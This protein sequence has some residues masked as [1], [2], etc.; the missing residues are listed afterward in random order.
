MSSISKKTK[1]QI[2]K[3]EAM[4]VAKRPIF[5]KN[6]RPIMT[7]RDL[8]SRGFV[9]FTSSV[10]VPGV[11]A[12]LSQRA[13]GIECV[14]KKDG[15]TPIPFMVMDLGGGANFAMGNVIAGKKGGQK[16]FLDDA[17]AA[18]LGC[19][20]DQNPKNN[21]AMAVPINDNADGNGLLFHANSGFLAG[22]RA[23]TSQTTRANVDGMLFCG[24]SGDDTRNNPLNPVYWIQSAGATGQLVDVVGAGDG[25]ARGRSQAPADSITAASSARV[26]N[27]VDAVSLI[28]TGLI[29]QILPNQADKIMKAA[30]NL[31]A[32]Q[33][34]AFNKKS[35]SEQ[36][37][38]LVQCGYIKATENLTKFTPNAVRPDNDPM[39]AQALAINNINANPNINNAFTLPNNNNEQDQVTTLAKLVIDGYAGSATMT[40]GG[41]DYHGQGRRTQTIK[42]FNA[43]VHAGRAFELAALKG[44]P[45]MMAFITDGGVSARTDVDN[46]PEAAGRFSFRS[47]SGTRS[48]AF[49][50]CFNPEG[51]ISTG[52]RQVGAFLDGSGAVD[53]EAS[54][55]GDSPINLTK[56]IA[57]NYMALSGT[58][59]DFAKVVQTNPFSDVAK[60][61]GFKS[62]K[63]QG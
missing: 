26:T 42:D 41:Y 15:G 49:M 24:R 28:D 4:P 51:L 46:S 8:I 2:E 19:P 14:S 60:V 53:L 52:V 33:L 29:G 30:Q 34:M 21:P 50:L 38:T 43:G 5:H 62:I 9:S 6:H 11:L 23:V 55:V 17:A 58:E 16:D 20:S 35:V 36:V 47:D 32:S 61:I 59:A 3:I 18:M 57:L 12:S 22:F 10:M 27:A 7:R 56:A 1:K 40:M 39:I 31:S 25:T 44:S 37:A 45:L 63:K 48:S 13:Y 54:A